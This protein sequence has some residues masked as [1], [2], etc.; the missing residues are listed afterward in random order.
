M[1]YIFAVFGKS[2]EQKY[3][4]F[5]KTQR[6]S[7][8]L[9]HPLNPNELF[10]IQENDYLLIDLN[11][12]N[13]QLQSKFKEVN[14]ILHASISENLEHLVEVRQFE[15]VQV[16][17]LDLNQKVFVNTDEHFNLI[18]EEKE[19][20]EDFPQNSGKIRIEFVHLNDGKQSFLV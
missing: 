9:V 1:Q 7:G 20:F 6:L 19:S 2:G 10:L 12:G 18:L 8:F 16:W 11:S 15:G 17:S 3:N 13:E 14:R 5:R 4:C